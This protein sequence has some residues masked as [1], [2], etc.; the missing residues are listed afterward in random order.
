[1]DKLPRQTLMRI[2]LGWAIFLL[3]LGGYWGHLHHTH[4]AQMQRAKEQ[5]HLRAAQTAHALALQTGTL[6]DQVHFLAQHLSEHWLK[7]NEAEFRRAISQAQKALPDGALVQVAIAD[8]L[9][10]IVFSN[11]TSDSKSASGVSIADREHFKIHSQRQPPQLFISHPLFGRVS[12]KWAVQFSLPIIRD[13]QFAGVTV[14]SISPEYLSRALR[15]I[16]HDPANVAILLRDDGAYL[17]RSHQLEEVLGKFVPSTRSF[18]TR[19]DLPSGAY[20]TVAPVDGVL[21]HYAWH[22]TANAPL[23]LSLGL[24]TEVALAPVVASLRDSKLHNALGSAML[25][26]AAALI[27]LLYIKNRRQTE[28]LRNS[29]EQ[30]SL[31]LRG[32]NLG[33]WDWNY[34]TNIPHF[35]ERWHELL[36]YGESDGRITPDNWTKLLHPDD[37]D[38]VREAFKSHLRGDTA[39]YEAEYRIRHRNG[40]WIWFLDRGQVVSRG[41]D[42]R[43]LRVAGTV[44]DI[45]TRKHAEVAEAQ[46]HERLATLLQRYPGGVLM[47]DEV[48]VV[49]MANQLFCDLFDLHEAPETLRGWSHGQ[50]QAHLG[51]LR[52]DWLHS[53]DGA[54]REQRKTLEATTVSGRILEIDWV[55]IAG[56]ND[57]L[58]RVWFVRDISQ[59]KQHEAQLTAMATTD[60]LTALPNRRSFMMYLNTLV[61]EVAEFPQDGGALLILDL[62]HFKQ[63]NDTYGHPA[64]DAVLQHA[65]RIIRNCLRESDRAARLGGEEFAVLLPRT[66]PQDA[67]MLADRLREALAGM[68]AATDKGDIVLTA[69]IGLTML[70]GLGAEEAIRQADEALYAAKAAGRNQVH[71]WGQA[72]S[73]G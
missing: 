46:Y 14:I 27:T 29:S 73:G 25:L 31:V 66:G 16:F 7:D 63:V 20:D 19:P 28:D 33:T 26:L 43:A 57:S 30:L 50:L 70:A 71:I 52:A 53:P 58:G 37:V 32:G 35:N 21:R 40:N 15:D 39:Q 23:I 12:K 4:Q 47:E 13:G 34:R 56:E 41:P 54:G 55:P 2:V 38:Q 5:M 72:P 18:L 44:L 59:R 17:A 69:S 65:A 62:D 64:G 1:M 48:D 67:R 10:N 3:V 8:T 49:V 22:R 9:G 60:A 24:G 61:R 11:L 51:A 42:G 45:T 6:I 68:P 36:G